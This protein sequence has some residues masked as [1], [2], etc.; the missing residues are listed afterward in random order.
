MVVTG[1][2]GMIESSYSIPY[3][4]VLNYVC[5]NNMWISERMSHLTVYL[6]YLCSTTF[7]AETGGVGNDLSTLAVHLIFE[8]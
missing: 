8:S 3:L 4:S 6:I 2:V 7:E 5:S 1:G